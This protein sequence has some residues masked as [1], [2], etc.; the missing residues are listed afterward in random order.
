VA[1]QKEAVK[2]IVMDK[3][4]TKL[5]EELVHLLEGGGAHATFKDAVKGLPAELRGVKHKELPYTIWQIVEHIR[6]AQWDM[7]EFSKDAAHH[8][9]PD[10]PDGYWPE[11]AGPASDAA[12]R[13]S[14]KQIESDLNEFIDLMKASDLY[15]RIPDGTGQTILREALQ[16]AD[17]TAYHTGEIVVLRRLLGA[18]K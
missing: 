7:L 6:L 4:N 3:S 1:I 10:W 13:K 15:A 8:K 5:I 12:W 2:F 9:S 18:W 16:I 14:I 17:H 11:E